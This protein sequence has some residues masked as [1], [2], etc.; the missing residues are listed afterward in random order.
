MDYKVFY[1]RNIA[2]YKRN[3]QY[4]RYKRGHLQYT[5]CTGLSYTTNNKALC[6]R[7]GL[8]KMD[9]MGDKFIMSEL[10]YSFIITDSYLQLTWC[11]LKRFNKYQMQH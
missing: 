8:A 6:V 7:N 10:T 2:W 11:E 5:A 3:Q 1:L 4:L 9:R